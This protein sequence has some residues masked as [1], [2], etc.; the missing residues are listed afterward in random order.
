MQ[1]PAERQEKVSATAIDT[2]KSIRWTE[3]DELSDMLEELPGQEQI[4]QL[5]ASLPTGVLRH[6]AADLLK[7]NVEVARDS[8]L[9]PYVFVRALSSW[10]ATTQEVAASKRGVNRILRQRDEMKGAQ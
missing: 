2:E 7:H 9:F 10:V 4:E 6:M 5:I 1:Q 3:E 8:S